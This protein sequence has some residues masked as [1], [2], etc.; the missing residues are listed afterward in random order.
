MSHCGVMCIQAHIYGNLYRRLFPL[1]SIFTQA[2]AYSPG[3][4]GVYPQLIAKEATPT[5]IRASVY[6]KLHIKNPT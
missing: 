3:K 2:V 6:M 5:V 4:V 1:A